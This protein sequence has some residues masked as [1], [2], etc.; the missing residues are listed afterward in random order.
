[1]YSHKGHHD[2]LLNVVRP[3]WT[4]GNA[5]IDSQPFREWLVG[6]FI[7]EDLTPRASGDVEIKWGVHEAGEGQ[8]EWTVNRTAT[9]IS[10]LIRGTDRILFPD[11]EVLLEREGDYVV[12]GPDIPHRWRAVTDCVVVTVRWPSA[13]NDSIVISDEIAHNWR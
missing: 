13:P 3:G 4:H 7:P 11:G 5:A 6:N 10:L 12:W 2:R 9:T 1:M 8:G